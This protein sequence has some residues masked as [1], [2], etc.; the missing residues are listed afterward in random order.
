[1]LLVMPALVLASARGE[2]GRW[3]AR[4]FAILGGA[5]Y[6]IYVLQN[7]IDQWFETLVPWALVPT[8]AG[9]GTLGALAVAAAIV[10]VALLCDRYYD[11]PLRRA[12]TRAWRSRTIVTGDR[13]VSAPRSVSGR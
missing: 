6:G 5:S 4:P 3:L 12:L 8:Y 11:L 1:V 10:A 7:P 9:T 2:P 13:P